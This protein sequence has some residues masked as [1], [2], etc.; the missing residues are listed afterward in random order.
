[1]VFAAGSVGMRMR[2]RCGRWHHGLSR[3]D[4]MARFMLF[5][6]VGGDLRMVDADI[7]DE[8]AQEPL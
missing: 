1:M 4:D 6:Q 8:T 7:A 2:L 3:Q 5:G